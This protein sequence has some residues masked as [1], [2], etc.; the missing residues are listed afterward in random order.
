MIYFELNSKKREVRDRE[1]TEKQWTE[2]ETE[3]KN[4]GDMKKN[5]EEKSL[6]AT[7]TTT[8]SVD[9]TLPKV[10]PVKWTVRML[11][12]YKNNNKKKIINIIK[13]L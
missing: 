6:S 13:N 5:G 11:C 10:N 8:S 1:G 12:K 3:S 9:D 4:D 7:T 2:I